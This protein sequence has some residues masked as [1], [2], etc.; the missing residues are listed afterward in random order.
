[1]EPRSGGGG[2]DEEERER[3]DDL[4]NAPQELSLRLLSASSHDSH[5]W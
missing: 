4:I 3:E 5:I 2:R 1:M